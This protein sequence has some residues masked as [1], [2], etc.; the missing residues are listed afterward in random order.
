M[1]EPSC[2]YHC[3]LNNAALRRLLEKSADEKVRKKAEGA[4]WVLEGN[5]KTQATG[6]SVGMCC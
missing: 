6:H 5:A 3:V 4:L 1:I 2:P